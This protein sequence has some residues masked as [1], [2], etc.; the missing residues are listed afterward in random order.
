MKYAHYLDFSDLSA[1][2]V[3]SLLARAAARKAEVRAGIR[4]PHLAG[5]LLMMIFERPST[6]TRASF[7]AAMAQSG[8]H[9]FVLDAAGMQRA[10]GESVADTARAISS[11]AD[12]VMIRAGDHNALAEFAVHSACPVINGLSD[13][14]HPCQTLADVMTFQELRGDLRGRKI[15]WIGD[16]NN[17]LFSWAEAAAMC[18]AE[19]SAACP[20]RYRPPQPPAAVS[21][22]DSPARAA[23]DADLVMTDVWASMGDKDAETRRRDFAG[24]AVDSA[25]MQRAK[26]DAVFMHCLPAHRGE[27]VAAE[28]IDGAQSAVWRQAEN[29]MHA[30]KAL[31]EL[32]MAAD[33]GRDSAKSRTR[34]FSFGRGGAKK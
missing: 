30:Q 1:A 25:L 23:E 8:G 21:W 15:A 18:G 7:A 20:P 28:V 26:K 17:V 3:R 29:R 34:K 33:D 13:R 4:P 12:A 5:R 11:M 2:E 10:R 14:S 22:A 32:L 31:L 19:I 6:R 16:F 24:Y 27:E 9:S